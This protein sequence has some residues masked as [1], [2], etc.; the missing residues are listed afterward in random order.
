MRKNCGIYLL[1]L[2]QAKQ[3]AHNS[4]PAANRNEPQKGD[5]HNEGTSLN[6]FTFLRVLGQGGFGKVLLA[7]SKSAGT[8]QHEEGLYAV[9]V[10]KKRDII[11]DN[12]VEFVM[13]ERDILNLVSG[14]PFMI[15]LFSSFQTEVIFQIS[16]SVS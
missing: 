7:E 9:K 11:K 13:A 5:D 8:L 4:Q 3:S 12:S 6:D 10:L 14:H 16:K 1:F 2:L 15:N